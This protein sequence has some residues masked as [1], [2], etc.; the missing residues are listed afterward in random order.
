MI[1]SEQL[2]YC[3][4]DVVDYNCTVG[5]AVVHGR[6][7]LVTLLTG[8]VPYLELDGCVVIQSNGLCEEG[9]ADG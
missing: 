7:G 2:S 5:V 4:S 6:Q 9:G 1:K 3:L 8:R